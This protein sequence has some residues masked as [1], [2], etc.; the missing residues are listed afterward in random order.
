[1]E[2]LQQGR[3]ISSL[4]RLEVMVRQGRAA[5]DALGVAVDGPV[6]VI[7]AIVTPQGPSSPIRRDHDADRFNSEGPRALGEEQLRLTVVRG[8]K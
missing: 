5:G 7:H 2:H 1:M 6:V 8:G 4:W 3:L